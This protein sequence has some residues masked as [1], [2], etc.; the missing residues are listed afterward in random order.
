MILCTYSSISTISQLPSG[1]FILNHVVPL[2]GEYLQLLF[3]ES[4]F[5]KELYVSRLTKAISYLLLL[6]SWISGLNF[7]LICELL[8]LNKM[9]NDSLGFVLRAI[10][11]VFRT[12]FSSRASIIII[13][14]DYFYVDIQNVS[15]PHLYLPLFVLLV[16][17]ITTNPCGRPTQICTV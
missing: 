10:F 1:T 3:D 11:S 9:L 4:I 14:T 6:S 13:R 5:G 2:S 17:S 7:V 15:S 16:K 8:S 12:I